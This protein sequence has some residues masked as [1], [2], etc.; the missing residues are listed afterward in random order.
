MKQRKP[1]ANMT[2]AGQ[3]SPAFSINFYSGRT[4]QSIRV[5]RMLWNRMVEEMCAC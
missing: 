2:L 1:H 3:V 5:K 4:E